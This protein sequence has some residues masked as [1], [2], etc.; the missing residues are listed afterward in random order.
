MTKNEQKNI[1]RVVN[2]FAIF[3]IIR[4]LEEY[5]VAPKFG[6][7]FSLM[8]CVLGIIVL[9]I[10]LRMDNKPLE[11]IGL[12]HSNH[13]IKK[14]F[15]IAVLLN[16]VPL[17][18]VYPLAFLYF[19]SIDRYSVITA[20]FGSAD[21]CYSNGVKTF[22]LW[23][24]FGF[25]VSLIRAAFYEL[26]FRGLLMKLCSKTFSFGVT[27]LIQSALYVLWFV[28]A[29]APDLDIKSVSSVVIVVLLILYSFMSAI[30]LGL[31]KYASGAVWLCFFDHLAFGFI[32]DVLHLQ[33]TGSGLIQ[34]YQSYLVL[35]AYQFVSLIIAFVYYLIKKKKI[36]RAM[37]ESKVRHHSA[38]GRSHAEKVSAA[39]EADGAAKEISSAEV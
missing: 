5:L 21:N 24:C 1:I 26:T 31:C 29:V 22:A 6:R 25:A 15:L 23:I 34:Y 10:Y 35:V 14:G 8:S 7:T 33:I 12:I 13:K 36:E 38:S 4:I 17:I 37:I 2:C 20:Y 11:K 9:L 39:G 16:A 32:T 28:I 30:K 27:N 3:F 19:K 18:T